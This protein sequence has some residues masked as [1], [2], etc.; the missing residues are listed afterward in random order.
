LKWAIA[1]GATAADFPAGKAEARN[2][3]TFGLATALLPLLTLSLRRLAR[4]VSMLAI[5]R[6]IAAPGQP[7]AAAS[8][9]SVKRNRSTIE[10]GY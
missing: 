8:R 10:S 4:N 2:L 7:D 9:A 1:C 6:L 5:S 3:R